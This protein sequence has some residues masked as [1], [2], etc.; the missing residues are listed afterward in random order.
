MR[1]HRPS[2]DESG[3]DI[4]DHCQIQPALSGPYGGDI[5]QPF[6][7]GSRGRE[8][9]LQEIGSYR[10]SVMTI[11]GTDTT[12]FLHSP[13]AC[14]LHQ[15][16]YTMLA[17]FNPPCSQ[18]S[19]HARTAINSSALPKSLSDLLSQ[20]LILPLALTWFAFAPGGVAAFG[21][22]QDTTHR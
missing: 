15:T 2:H 4:Q 10:I 7:I 12:L 17:A 14:L 6:S 11:G 8:I 1:S 9:A 20:S 16:G 22:V 19:L 13:Q 3:I 21:H 18:F 5:S